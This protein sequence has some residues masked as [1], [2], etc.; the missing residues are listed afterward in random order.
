MSELQSSNGL[1]TAILEET[2]GGATTS[3]GYNVYLETKELWSSRIRVAELYGTT[4]SE[5]AYGLDFVWRSPVELELRYKQSKIAPETPIEVLLDDVIYRVE[6][7]PGIE[8]EHAPC[9]GMLY[10]S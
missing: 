6:L 4:R 3:F 8:N 10:N 1:V 9:G 5:C 2:N 7:R